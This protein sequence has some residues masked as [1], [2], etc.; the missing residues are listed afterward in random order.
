MEETEDLQPQREAMSTAGL[1]SVCSTSVWG[2]EAL[3]GAGLAQ[4]NA[5]HC[6]LA[7]CPS[8]VCHAAIWFRLRLPLLSVSPEFFDEG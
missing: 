5:V 8:G 7:S 4:G 3:Q 6:F 2:P 1:S